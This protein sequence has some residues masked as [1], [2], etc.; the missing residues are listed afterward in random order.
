MAQFAGNA[1]LAEPSPL[2]AHK[3]RRTP[4]KCK[5]VYLVLALGE[6]TAVQAVVGSTVWA[7]RRLRKAK[8]S[9]MS[10]G[11]DALYSVCP[12]LSFS[13]PSMYGID[14]FMTSNLAIKRRRTGVGNCEIGEASLHE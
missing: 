11:S 13:F 8:V 10:A 9:G 1:H 6:E 5:N 4:L 3:A 12:Q 2:F 14:I 7:F